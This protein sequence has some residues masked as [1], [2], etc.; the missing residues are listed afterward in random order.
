MS[1]PTKVAPCSLSV[2]AIIKRGKTVANKAA[3]SVLQLY[4]FDTEV[5]S[6]GKVPIIAEFHEQKEPFGKGGGGAGRVCNA[7]EATA[8]HQQFKEITWVI[9]R[10]LPDTRKVISNIGQTVQQHPVKLSK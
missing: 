1:S 10:C 3:T 9:K 5:L 6:W 8:K 2:A 7:F 4:T